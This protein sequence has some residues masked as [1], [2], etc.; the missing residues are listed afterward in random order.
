[1]GCWNA[2]DGLTQLAIHAD[3]PVRLI[4][5]TGNPHGDVGG[6]GYCYSTGLYEPF[7]LPIKGVYDDYGCI[8]EIVEDLNTDFIVRWFEERYKEGKLVFTSR[9]E[10]QDL[11][12]TGRRETGDLG[13]RGRVDEK[14]RS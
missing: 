11:R 14:V 10:P 7:G 12:R 6:G 9:A 2:T 8:D 3:A 13:G 1:M 5:I 4:L